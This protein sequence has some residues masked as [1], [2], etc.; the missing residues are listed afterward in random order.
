MIDRFT[1]LMKAMFN[2]GISKM[3]TPEILA[4]QA[5]MEIESSVKKVREAVVNSIA[6]EKLLEQQLKK[7]VEELLTWEKRAAT[8]VEHNNDEVAKQCL[9]KKQELN[10]SAQSLTVQLAEQKKSS[11][12]LK[13]RQAELDEKFRDFQK[14]KDVITARGKA[15]EALAKANDLISSSSGGTGMDKWEQKIREKEIMSEVTR[16]TSGSDVEDKFKALDK[17]S[18]LDDELAALKAKVGTPKLV[19]SQE[20]TPTIVDDNLPMIIDVDEVEGDE[21]GKPGSK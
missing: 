3:E 10:Q 20:P 4:E 7:N 2:K 15:G 9:L 8:A 16:Q 19:V 11:A 6:N 5:Q 14:K 12:S 1:S 18:Q 17:N 13:E 21:K